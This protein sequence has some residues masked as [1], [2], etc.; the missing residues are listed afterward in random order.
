M[1]RLTL[2]LLGGFRAFL[3]GEPITN[4]TSDKT[5]ALLVYLSV[6]ANRPH[7]RESLS[8]LLWPNVIEA[9][10]RQSLSQA[11]SQLRKA[12]K[13]DDRARPFLLAD[14]DTVRFNPAS[15]Y[16]LDI[17]QLG[18][19]ALNASANGLNHALS[20]SEFPSVL[21]SYQGPF[22]GGFT[23]PDAE[24]FEE[25]VLIQ[26][27]NVERRAL[28]QLDKVVAAS[29]EHGDYSHAIAA[30][31][32]QLEIDPWREEAH[33]NLMRAYALNKQRSE[34]LTQ[35]EK[36]K[37][38]LR[39]ALG[40]EP[41][42][43][44]KALLVQI[45]KDE[46]QGKPA[47][48]ATAKEPTRILALPAALTPFVGR[49]GELAALAELIKNPEARLITLAGT[50]G[51]GKTRLAIQAAAQA[52]RDFDGV[53]FVPL[54][55]V[56][57]ADAIPAAIAQTL[58]LNLYRPTGLRDELLGAMR[59]QSLLLVLD[60]FE[61]LLN[62]G[63]GPES[64][65]FVTDLLLTAPGLKLII[66]SREPL[67]LQ[68]EWVWE[69]HGL[70]GDAKTLF[71]Q[72]AQRARVG[73]VLTVEEE[74]AV[75]RICALVGG[76]PLGIELAASWARLLS[77]AD[78]ANEIEKNIGFL[79]TTARFVPERQ[80]SIVAVLEHSWALLSE[81]ERQVLMRLSLFAG[82]FERD[83]ARAVAGA[84]LP[85][86]S[87]LVSKSLIRR[88]DGRRFELH[89]LIRQFASARLT[90]Q[91]AAADA[92]AQFFVAYAAANGYQ[93]LPAEHHT[94]FSEIGRE[95]AN[96]EA[97]CAHLLSNDQGLQAAHM[98]GSLLSLWLKEQRDTAFGLNLIRRIRAWAVQAGAQWPP[99]THVQLLSAQVT[100]LAL[101]T[102]VTALAD[103]LAVA[104]IA[105]RA[106][107]PESSFHTLAYGLAALAW[108]RIR[109]GRMD[110][111]LTML[112][113]SVVHFRR[114]NDPFGLAWSL[115]GLSL[116]LD[117]QR[118]AAE[119]LEAIK[120]CV[121]LCRNLNDPH[122]LAIALGGQAERERAQGDLN[123]AL[124]HYTECIHLLESV[125]DQQNLLL[126]KLNHLGACILLERRAEIEMLS[127]QVALLVARSGELP[128]GHTRAYLLLD[129]AGYELLHSHLDRSAELLSASQAVL[130]R[131]GSSL[132]PADRRTFEFIRGRLFEKLPPEHFDHHWRLGEVGDDTA[133]LS[134]ALA[135]ISA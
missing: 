13:D 78:I 101:T 77:C 85:V 23:I 99:D 55:A 129:L 88:V 130:A 26:R 2:Q 134:G 60:N 30:A 39:E 43:E 25:W 62:T 69:V 87:N 18:A 46:V 68:G 114:I 132:Q 115:R 20:P 15:D 84:T 42:A 49:E 74:Q 111:A 128:R 29:I 59:D 80:R 41:S 102:N 122:S 11:L 126:C 70:G 1:A 24:G 44:T 12:L 35:F 3:D 71:V 45:Q 135:R 90:D 117:A 93:A 76:M 116:A 9:A 103:E 5:R 4:F 51:M 50:G 65:G 67:N 34:A 52:Q 72:S 89:E 54:A 61:Q 8:A 31:H 125:G 92:H 19:G 113:E 82:G 83:A 107:P 127:Q 10:A 109:Q 106:A 133:L 56:N 86:L 91:A 119:G 123:S 53:A 98:I 112:E 131:H 120:E 124:V 36:C 47:A 6:E 108:V 22:L 97:A 100:M 38:V 17:D 94:R 33:R 73:F 104:L 32:K 66:T 37:Q 95:Q 27:E 7:R 40:V 16:A 21:S 64:A 28:D 48:T 75:N 57:E 81:E 58:G 110:E 121:S 105:L 96:I 63:N 118:H 14:R 79:S